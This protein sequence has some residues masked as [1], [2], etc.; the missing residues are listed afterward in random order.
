MCVGM[1][2]TEPIKFLAE[3]NMP[4]RQTSRRLFPVT[5]PRKGAI[6]VLAA[7]LLIAMLGM[8]AFERD[9]QGMVTGFRSSAGRVRHLLFTKQP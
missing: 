7:F 3:S 2:G 9:A 8:L 5:R 1:F 4:I 6:V